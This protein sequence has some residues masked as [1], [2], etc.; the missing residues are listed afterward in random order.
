[1]CMSKIQRTTALGLIGVAL[2]VLVISISH[3]LATNTGGPIYMV[4]ALDAQ[5][6]D[7]PAAWINRTLRVRARAEACLLG[8]DGPG[9]PCIEQHPVLVDAG[10]GQ[11]SAALPLRRAHASP[12]LALLRRLPQ[13][14]RLVP[15]PQAVHWG[16]VAT[17]RVRIR[18]VPAGFC[19]APPCYQALLDAA[20]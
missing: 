7:H 4:A 17:F 9:A 2:L 12:L 20:P 8:M 10:L 11:P 18:A 16:E 5:L 14:D 3:S 15:A 19:A 6:A 1:M 13:V